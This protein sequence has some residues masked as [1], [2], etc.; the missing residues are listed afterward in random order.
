[1]KIITGLHDK[2]KP[3]NTRTDLNSVPTYCD[4]IVDSL[5]QTKGN[6]STDSIRLFKLALKIPDLI[7]P[8]AI[9]E[10]AFDRIYES[11]AANPA[12]YLS[13][14]HGQMMIKLDEWKKIPSA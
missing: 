13:W 11:C 1:M 3:P 14:A 5:T 9:E 7:A 6:D 12:G 10:Y 8:Y 4:I 2:L